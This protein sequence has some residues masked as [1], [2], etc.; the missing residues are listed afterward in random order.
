MVNG[1]LAL[2]AVITL[3]VG[4]TYAVSSHRIA[5]TPAQSPGAKR[6]L[7]LF[8]LWWACLAVNM[9]VAGAA[10]IAGATS[11]LTFEVQFAVALL[12][13][14]LLVISMVGLMYYLLYLLTGRELLVP[15][16]VTYGTYYLALVYAF[17]QNAPDT[18]V[19]GDWRTDVVPSSPVQGWSSALAFFMVILPPVAA[20]LAYFRLFFQVEDRTT[21]FRIAFIAWPIVVWWVLAVLA[22]QRWFLDSGPL[23]VT[24]RVL[25]LLAALSVLAAYHPPAW[26]RERFRLRAAGEMP[27]ERAT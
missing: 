4:A 8:A 24:Q 22:G 17:V 6:A 23:Q 13:R 14:L 12:Q 5:T 27:A 25:S 1:T 10:Y 9:T 19:V 26:M 7:S 3:V 16:V 11:V 21:K 15:L 20:A 18:L 2:S